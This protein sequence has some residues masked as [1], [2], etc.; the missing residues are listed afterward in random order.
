MLG[1][2]LIRGGI[3]RLV[4]GVG[5][6]SETVARAMTRVYTGATKKG[7]VLATDHAGMNITRMLP[8]A[9]VLFRGDLGYVVEVNPDVRTGEKWEVHDGIYGEETIGITEDHPI[10]TTHS[11]DDRDNLFFF[12]HLQ[13]QLGPNAAEGILVVTAGYTVIGY[14]TVRCDKLVLGINGTVNI[15]EVYGYDGADLNNQEVAAA[16]GLGLF[17]CVQRPDH[18]HINDE[19]RIRT[20]VYE[21]LIQ[22]DRQI[23]ISHHLTMCGLNDAIPPMAVN[24]LERGPFIGQD[25]ASEIGRIIND[26]Y[27]PYGDG[28]ASINGPTLIGKKAKW[29]AYS[30]LNNLSA[31]DVLIQQE[32][33]Q[34]VRNQAVATAAVERAREL[35]K[36]VQRVGEAKKA[37]QGNS[38]GCRMAQPIQNTILSSPVAAAFTMQ[39]RLRLPAPRK[40]KDITTVFDRDMPISDQERVKR[41]RKTIEKE[42]IP[43]GK[44]AHVD[45]LLQPQPNPYGLGKNKRGTTWYMM[46][47]GGARR[48]I[49]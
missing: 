43:E 21:M 20:P 3:G 5:G 8:M 13:S 16:H 38:R 42:M 49:S 35:H 32:E 47:S 15:G 33:H 45:S 18:K 10:Q 19:N 23:R 14:D 27:E 12:R 29:Q 4:P 36:R 39:Q 44:H 40:S 48:G 37:K 22:S 25:D 46:W 28:G 2:S 24:E 34:R 41:Q 7:G 17:G 26:E 31:V 1:A 9:A 11:M 6:T 30:R